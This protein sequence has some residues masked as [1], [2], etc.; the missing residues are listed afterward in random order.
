MI[1]AWGARPAL[2]VSVTVAVCRP[3]CNCPAWA[4]TAKYS[5]VGVVNP[6]PDSLSQ[7]GSPAA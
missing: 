6:T 5:V 2:S 4:P 3:G 1:V 7:A